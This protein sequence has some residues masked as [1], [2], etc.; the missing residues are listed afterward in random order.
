MRLRQRSTDAKHDYC[1]GLDHEHK[2]PFLGG[3]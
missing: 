1:H 2:N 3:G